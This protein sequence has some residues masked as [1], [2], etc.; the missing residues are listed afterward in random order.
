MNEV[1]K[2]HPINLV[3]NSKDKLVT[4]TIISLIGDL[5]FQSSM[6]LNSFIVHKNTSLIQVLYKFSSQLL[7]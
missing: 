6:Q 1:E 7:A 2:S 5:E 4:R 3:L